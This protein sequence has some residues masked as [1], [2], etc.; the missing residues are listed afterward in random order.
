MMN[1]A[2]KQWEGSV[3]DGR[4]ALRELQGSSD[5]SVVFLTNHGPQAQTAAI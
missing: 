2:W 1:Q 5:H 4:F 3:V